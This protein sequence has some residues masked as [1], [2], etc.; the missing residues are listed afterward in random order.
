LLERKISITSSP[1]RDQEGEAP[2]KQ[3]QDGKM[4]EEE[5]GDISKPSSS[6][7]DDDK[8]KGKRMRVLK[9]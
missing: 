1:S 2:K 8:Q 9:L 3:L 6:P 7:V 4:P 5:D